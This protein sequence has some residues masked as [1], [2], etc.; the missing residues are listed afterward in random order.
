M[1]PEG[2]IVA[3][4][5]NRC[6]LLGL[7]QRKLSYEGRNNA[8][9]R[10]VWGDGAMAFI[11]VKAPGKKPRLLQERELS[12]LARSGCLTAVVSTEDEVDL[13]LGELLSKASESVS[14]PSHC[15]RSY[16]DL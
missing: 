15:W 4:L 5:V 12:R 14:R 8:P 16:P 3:Y 2:K 9:D 6:A 7:E 1:T 11:E 13:V 10:M